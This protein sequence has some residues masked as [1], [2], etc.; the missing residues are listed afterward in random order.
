MRAAKIYLVLMGVSTFL[1]GVG[2]L[3]A[4]VK[5]LEPMGFAA[6][7]ASALTDIRATYGGLQIGCGLFLLYCLAPARLRMG[8]AFS[9]L[10]IA[11]VAG[12]RLIGLAIDRDVT[13]TLQ[14]TAGLEVALAIVALILLVRMPRKS[15]D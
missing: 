9:V 12:S 3:F 6:L 7:Q 2:Y 5:M 1:F 4:P 15:V 13:Q 10:S 14:I 11:A 8:L